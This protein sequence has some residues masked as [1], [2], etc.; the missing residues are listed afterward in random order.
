MMHVKL[1]YK[2]PN[3]TRS[4]RIDHVAY[5]QA[6]GWHNVSADFQ[7]A[8]A[9]AGFAMRLRGDADVAHWHLGSIANL[10]EVAIANTNSR[11]HRRERKAFLELVRQADQLDNRY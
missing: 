3:A 2:D 1:R 7:F 10:A 8:A 5:D 11:A 4:R 9:V 6:Y